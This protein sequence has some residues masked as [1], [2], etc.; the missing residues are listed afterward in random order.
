MVSKLK[1]AGV[2]P[3]D[4]LY[5]VDARP[6][7]SIE[8]Y[9]SYRP[10]R[11]VNELEMSRLRRNRKEVSDAVLARMLD[12]VK[13]KLGE[14]RPVYLIMKYENY[15][16]LKTFSRSL[17]FRALFG[18]GEQGTHPRQMVITQEFPMTKPQ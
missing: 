17:P 12:E 7:S 8:F 9:Y 2:T 4:S 11:L 6:D 16:R 13:K 5:I 10:Q 1:A 14:P 3:A 15:V 18:T